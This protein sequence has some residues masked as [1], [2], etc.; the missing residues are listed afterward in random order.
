MLSIGPTSFG[1]VNLRLNLTKIDT[2]GFLTH[3]VRMCHD[4]CHTKSLP[5]SDL[6]KGVISKMATTMSASILHWLYLNN[7]SI[8]KD[9]VLTY[10]AQQS[11]GITEIT[12]D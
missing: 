6:G 10:T 12:N 8:L 5:K 11:N 2:K 3:F 1:R 9:G 7:N 4:K